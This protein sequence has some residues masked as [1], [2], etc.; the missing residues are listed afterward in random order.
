MSIDSKLF[1]TTRSWDG[2]GGSVTFQN[3]HKVVCAD[4]N[5]PPQRMHQH[6]TQD[7]RGTEEPGSQGNLNG[8]LLFWSIRRAR[9]V[10]AHGPQAAREGEVHAGP[11]SASQVDC[12]VPAVLETFEWLLTQHHGLRRCQAYGSYVSGH[13]YIAN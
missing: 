13:Q 1:V 2:L 6:K 11:F 9:G 5:H 4:R 7:S 10:L 8:Q 12:E 3:L